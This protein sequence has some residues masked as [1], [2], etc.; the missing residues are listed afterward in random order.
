MGDELEE[1]APLTAAE[2]LTFGPVVESAVW[3]PSWVAEA[4]APIAVAAGRPKFGKVFDDQ[5]VGKAVIIRPCM[6]R[7][8]R[9]RGLSPIYM[10]KMLEAHGGVF[11]GWPMFRDHAPRVA[12]AMQK[13]GRSVNELGGQ[14]LRG[15]WSKDFT[16]EG[17]GDYGYQKGAVLAEVWATPLVRRIVGENPNLLHTSINAWPTAG[18]PGSAPWRPGSKGMVIEGIRR[19]PQGSVD[20]VVRG[21]AGGRLLVEGVDGEPAWPEPGEWTSE[22]LDLVVSLAESLYASRQMTTI[23]LPKDPNELQAFLQ[24]NAPHLLP[25]LS[26][27]SIVV[28]LN[29]ANADEAE[30]AKLMK[31]GMSMS[32]AWTKV[33][34]GKSSDKGD[35]KVSE[36]LTE[37]DVRKILAESTASMP[38]TEQFET[39]LREQTEQMISERAEQDRLSGIAHGLIESAIGV[40]KTWKAD[41]KA[42]YTP[43]ENGTPQSLLV[44]SEDLSADDG[45][46]LTARQ[47]VEARVEA[48]LEH[49]RDLL[50]EAQGK[51]RVRG[52]GGTKRD[53]QEDASATT[54]GGTPHWR[55]A[56]KDL[57]ISESEDKAVELFGGKVQG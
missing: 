19:Q 17:D 44:E 30:V 5:G 47:V 49:V 57:G 45:K 36:G 15:G 41:L 8:A 25:A 55:T 18:K 14:V 53:P 48:D 33:K 13:A 16:Q 21:G 46:T 34:A 7:G 28:T 23:A 27:S 38:T 29:E 42:R 56:F 32:A 39:R 20:F 3:T 9:L 26:D 43:T 6:S 51:P 52:E 24:E 50:A 37:A 54:S 4:R 10:P 31:G 11:D 12:E 40:P 22:E 2:I 35:D 1:D